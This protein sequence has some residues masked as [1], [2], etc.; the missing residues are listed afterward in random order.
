MEEQDDTDESEIIPDWEQCKCGN[1]QGDLSP[2]PFALE[3]GQIELICN[4]CDR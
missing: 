4:C 2:C 3:I 1:R